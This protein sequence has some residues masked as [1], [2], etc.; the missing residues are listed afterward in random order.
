[1]TRLF[2][3]ILF[4]MLY[5]LALNAQETEGEWITRFE[6]SGY[7]ET[8]DYAETM[9]YLNK[10]ADYSEYAVVKSM[11][12]SPQG[13]E[14]NY[15]IV[16]KDKTF[17][18]EFARETDKPV[19]L[20]LNGIHSGEINGK[21]ASFLLLRDILVTKEN[22]SYLDHLNLIVVPIF[23]VDAHERRGPYNRINQI[24][25][26]EMGWRV[27]AQ[28]LNLNRDFMKADA[29]E[30]QYFLKLYNSWLPDF[31]IDVH[32]TD[33]SDYQYH[34]TYAIEKHEN[35]TPAIGKWVKKVFNPSI[36]K[37]V[38]EK[39]FLISPYVGYVD[40]DL[41]KGLYD[42][43]P[44]P[45]FS[46]GFAAVQ[47]RPGLLIE[48]HILKS[49]KDRVYSTKAVLESVIELINSDPETIIKLGKNADEY[50][51]E[52]YAENKEPYPI[53]FERSARH[54][55]VVYKAIEVEMVESAVAGGK[56]RNFTGKPYEI[57]VPYYNDGMMKTEVTLPE[58]YIVPAEWQNVIDR[59]HIHGVK[60]YPLE[61][62]QK[63]IVERY[64]FY[65]VK[66]PASPYEGR[67]LPDYHYMKYTDTVEVYSGDYIIPTDQRALGIIA[68]LLEPV[69]ED[70]FVKW[71]F[72]N[73]IFER[74]EYFEDYAMD[75]I[76]EKMYEDDLDLQREFNAMLR[77]D[78]EF[79]VNTRAR[80]NFF[81][82][83]TP[84]YDSHYNVYPVMRVVEEYDD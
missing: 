47:N 74:K 42:W 32:S 28:N 24:G 56:V 14:I 17:S 81:Y 50:T 72:F 76:A 10:L 33:G 82:E 9:D 63:Y 40:G 67:F 1:M 7:L 70:S 11:G 35:V 8:P 60:M 39:G 6:A 62:A 68:N 31:F 57:K 22:A 61:E 2:Q 49:Y 5:S 25:P 54:D 64:K 18:P 79:A 26:K 59:L 34:T 48:S 46:N 75:P 12:K 16:S 43:I 44:L 37:S 65:D 73:I 23:S 66:F 58:Y 19:M 27:T 30:M 51:I 45:R 20:I 53:G 38:E 77:S 55:S 3:I 84:Y 41:R 69:G 15:I 21:D 71:G 36:L 83:K 4:V 13:R 29:P 52:H 80:L 78:K